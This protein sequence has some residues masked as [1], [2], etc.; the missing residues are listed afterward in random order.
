[1]KRRVFMNWVGVSFMAASLPVAIA[2]CS[3]ATEAESETAA[4][5]GADEAVDTDVREDGFA[6]LGTVSELDSTGFLAS[7]N[8]AGGSVI[9]VRVPANSESV[10]AL[11]SL[12]THRGCTVDWADSE[13]SC[14]CHGSTFSTDGE[15]TNGP[16]TE[17]LSAYEA[18]IEDDLV[19]VM[20]S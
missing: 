13:F 15:V 1:M 4:D 16:A 3:P 9:A 18:K 5:P 12:C 2:A 8:F 11:N 20:A 14:A 19:L 17:A 7:K 6:A 10:I